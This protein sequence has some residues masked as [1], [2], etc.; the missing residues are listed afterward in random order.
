MSREILEAMTA[1]GREKGISPEKLMAALNRADEIGGE[2]R[3]FIQDKMAT[4]PRYIKA[5]KAW[6]KL[7]GKDF[8][9]KD[10]VAAK[11]KAAEA[12]RDSETAIRAAIEAGNPPPPP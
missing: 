3:D 2:V 6:A 10:E 9:S 4:E 7:V 8:E 12:K 1:L 5:R 11:A